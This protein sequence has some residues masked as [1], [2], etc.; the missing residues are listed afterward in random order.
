MIDI[1]KKTGL[2]IR[3]VDFFPNTP[4]INKIMC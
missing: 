4:L 2:K 3:E 1:F